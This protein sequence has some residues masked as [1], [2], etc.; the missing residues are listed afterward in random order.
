MPT[1]V[2]ITLACTADATP[3]GELRLPGWLP[4]EPGDQSEMGVGE[5]VPCVANLGGWRPELVEIPPPWWTVYRFRGFY[6]YSDLLCLEN[7][8]RSVTNLPHIPPFLA[9]KPCLLPSSLPHSH[10]HGS[11][12]VFSQAPF[13]REPRQRYKWRASRLKVCNSENLWRIF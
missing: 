5:S 4:E 6:S 3:V 12:E 10:L 1:E 11:Q 7:M 8:A 13:S 9:S 2:P